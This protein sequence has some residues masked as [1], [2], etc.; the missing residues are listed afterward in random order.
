[1]RT[2]MFAEALRVLTILLIAVVPPGVLCDDR[3]ADNEPS[4]GSED[5]DK[6]TLDRDGDP[7]PAGAILRLGSTRFRTDVVGSV[8]AGVAFTPDGKTVISAAVTGRAVQVWDTETGKLRRQISTKNIS[9]RDLNV[10]RDGQTIAVSG[11]AYVEIRKRADYVTAIYDVAT[12]K[13]RQILTRETAEF[14]AFPHAIVLTPDGNTLLSR[15]KLGAIRV[16][17]VATGK[18]VSKR[19]MPL[20]RGN[21][22]PMVISADG[23]TVAFAG[24]EKLYAWKWQDEKEP[25]EL[26]SIDKKV[27]RS[28]AF[29]PDAKMLLEYD[30]E[31]VHVWNVA[32]GGV[33][34]TLEIPDVDKRR[35]TLGSVTCTPDGTIAIA[36]SRGVINY[37]DLETGKARAQFKV[38]PHADMLAVSP[39]SRCLALAGGASLGLWTV[40]EGT[41]TGPGREGPSSP[42][43]LLAVSDK[44]AV[45]AGNDDTA[46]IWDLTTGAPLHALQDDYLVRA[47]ALSHDDK[48]AATSSQ[49]NSVCIW[50]VKSGKRLHK[51]AGHGEAGGERRLCFTP[52]GKYLLSWGDDFY[53]RKFAT[54]TGKVSTEQVL[55]PTGFKIPADAATPQE[56]D[57]IRLILALGGFEAAFAPTGT[58]LLLCVDA[59]WHVFDLNTGKDIL[60]VPDR[61]GSRLSAA[62]SGNGK[63]FAAGSPKA[64]KSDCALSVWE[65]S[66]GK[67]ELYITNLGEAVWSVTFSPD[68][69]WVAGATSDPHGIRWWDIAEHE[70]LGSIKDIPCRVRSLAFTPDGKRI[71]AGLE[72]CTAL[73]WEVPRK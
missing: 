43:S 17:E 71:V 32:D 65:T 62:V 54:D 73:V 44:L 7:L 37:W 72:N 15:D 19:D 61:N 21:Q 30:G 53:F 56:A 59:Q 14:Q 60:Q 13:E 63:Y 10:S 70:E 69:K 3:V 6:K 45:T 9:I 22:T 20:P 57:Q 42:I 46:R 47:V 18:E 35:G 48:L 33:A 50:D 36:V 39:D 55:R 5:K 64:G 51:L 27:P 4:S 34:Q 23:S 11:L 1:M 52:D 26:G 12:G 58:S 66:S 24:P 67:L 41:P 8:S 2:I 31:R 25:R 28:M 40:P 49:D 16:E 68:L 38:P 29:S